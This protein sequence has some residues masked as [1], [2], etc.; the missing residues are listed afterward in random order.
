MKYIKIIL[1]IIFL[2]SCTRSAPES[3]TVILP[4]TLINRQ[5]SAVDI[6]SATTD[7]QVEQSAETGIQFKIDNNGITWIVEP[8]LE[9]DSVYFCRLCGYTANSF[10][11][12]LDKTT[13][14][15]DRYHDGHGGPHSLEWIYDSENEMFGFYRSGWDEEVEIY[16]IN[17]FFEYFSIYADTLKFVRQVNY[18]DII[19]DRDEWWG[20]SYK[21]G[22]KYENSKFAISYDNKLLTEF[23]YDKPDNLTNVLIYRNAIP[24]SKNDKW[25]FIDTKGNIIIPL[26][27]DHVASS[28]GETAFVKLN[29]KY[30]IIDVRLSAGN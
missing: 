10:T 22:E 14:E 30:G 28:D 26:I 2:N 25:G 5:S 7:M 4:F 17:Q 11:Y 12:I 3:D 9:Y 19:I 21:L 1:I 15:I 23:I 24:V 13:G 27:F 18:S 29:G 8:T 16:K 20:K 6:Q